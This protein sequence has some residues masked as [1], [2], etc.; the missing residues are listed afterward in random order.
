VEIC[1][2]FSTSGEKDKKNDQTGAARPFVGGI[3]IKKEKK[4]ISSW[5]GERGGLGG[6]YHRGNAHKSK[7]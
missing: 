6:G 4:D 2:G 5:G 1:V 7:K 3:K